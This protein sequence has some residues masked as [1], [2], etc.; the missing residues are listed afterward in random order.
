M[1]SV[2]RT[3]MLVM[4]CLLYT[5]MTL[6]VLEFRQEDTLGGIHMAKPKLGANCNDDLN[7]S[8]VN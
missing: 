8:R 2:S 7:F 4:L 5:D 6:L 3:E 1:V